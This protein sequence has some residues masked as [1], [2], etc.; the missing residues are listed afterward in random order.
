MM[1][2]SSAKHFLKIT[3][4]DK[5]C[6]PYDRNF[7]QKLIDGGVYPIEYRYPNGRV[8]SLPDNWE[9]INQRLMQPQPYLSLWQSSDEAFRK[10]RQANAH[11]FK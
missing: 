9:E 2:K 5:K 1:S 10:F 4:S 8:P 7:A 6:R 3:P 11:A